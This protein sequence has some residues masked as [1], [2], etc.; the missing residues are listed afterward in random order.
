MKRKI[1]V[2]LDSEQYSQ[3]LADGL[4]LATLETLGVSEWDGYAKAVA[5]FNADIRSIIREEANI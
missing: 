5:E 3:L 1:T 2:T 4:F